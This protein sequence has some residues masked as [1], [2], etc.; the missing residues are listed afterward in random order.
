MVNRVQANIA[1][2]KVQGSIR[3]CCRK[4]S[5]F[6]HSRRPEWPLR[7]ARSG[8]PLPLPDDAEG[9]MPCA[10]LPFAPSQADR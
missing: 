4:W 3:P 2:L 10:I 1:P 6:A 8:G 5:Q 7:N 9:Q